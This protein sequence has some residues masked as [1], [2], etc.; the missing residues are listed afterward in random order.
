[1]GERIVTAD[2]EGN[3]KLWQTATQQL[4]QVMRVGAEIP[5]VLD[6]AQENLIAVG[7]D[8][9]KARLWN[10]ATGE[11]IITLYGYGGE[12][13]AID[14]L[15]DASA[16][17]FGYP[18]G[19]ILIYRLRDMD[20]HQVSILE[21][22]DAGELN[23]LA[24]Q[25]NLQPLPFPGSFVLATVSNFEYARFWDIFCFGHPCTYDT[26]A[27]MAY[28]SNLTFNHDGSLLVIAGK[29]TTAGGGC[30]TNP[31]NLE[32]VDARYIQDSVNVYPVIATLEGHTD[33]FEDVTFSPDDRFI[34]SA[35]NDGV[36]LIWGVHHLIDDDN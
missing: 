13:W 24:F 15:P 12:V 14:L 29:E 5:L 9:G 21:N 25:P 32:I 28:P 17:A 33:F 35:S 22:L 6:T 36:I 8:R 4:L 26:S 19:D 23:D 18:F 10:A 20:A 11:Q 34:A 7:Y 3:V 2:F 30:F 27:S 31:C 1:D 16:I